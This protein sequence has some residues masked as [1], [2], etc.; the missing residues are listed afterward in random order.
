MNRGEEPRLDRGICVSLP[1]PGPWE[2]KFCRIGLVSDPEGG[3][4]RVDSYSRAHSADLMGSYLKYLGTTA[5]SPDAAEFL[6][7]KMQV[8]LLYR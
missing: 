6:T 4:G 7:P 8:S 2:E 5:E 1:N 3:R